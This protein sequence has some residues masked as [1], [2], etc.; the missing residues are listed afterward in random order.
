[1][2]ASVKVYQK[3]AKENAS[4]QIIK[5]KNE[6]FNKWTEIEDNFSPLTDIDDKENLRDMFLETIRLGIINTGKDYISV[7]SKL[8]SEDKERG[9]RWLQTIVDHI[10]TSALKIMPTFKR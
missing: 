3:I 6:F 4:S 5:Q 1:M 9:T 10:T 7:I 8:N 2:P